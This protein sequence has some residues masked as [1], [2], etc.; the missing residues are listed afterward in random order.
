M[1]AAF[2]DLRERQKALNKLK[3]TEQEKQQNEPSK[4]KRFYDLKQVQ[5]FFF[6]ENIYAK[7][8]F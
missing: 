6:C 4:R 1:A 8:V 2:V 3:Q 7:N 5:C